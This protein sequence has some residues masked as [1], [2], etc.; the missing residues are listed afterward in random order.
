M[1]GQ[2]AIVI[3]ACIFIFAGTFACGADW[4]QWRGADRDGRWDE[5]GIVSK[6]DSDTLDTVWR[7]EVANGYSGP[8]VADGRVYVT[9]RVEEPIELERVHCFDVKTGDSLWTHKYECDYRRVGYPDGPRASVSID[10]SNAYSVGTMGHLFCLNSKTGKVK[11][12]KEP[13]KDYELK[14]PVWGVSASPM[15]EG[16]LLIV[17]IGAKDGGCIVA[18][19]KISGEEK[20][21]ALDDKASYSSP[22]IVKQAAKRLLICVTGQRVVGLDPQTGKLF[23]EHPFKPKKMVITVPTPVF[24]NNYLFVSSFYDGSLVLKLNPDKL[25]VQK[26]WRRIG[27]NETNTDS[28]HCMISTPVILGEHIY[29]V[30]SYGEL[31]CLDIHTGDRIWEDLTAVPK[32]RWANIHMV[33][34]GKNI[35]MFN[36]RGELVIGRLSPKG[37]QEIS[38]AKLIEP[39]K[40]QLG[41]RNGVCWAHPAY[42]N[43][44]IFI[45]NDNELVCASFAEKK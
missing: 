30:D 42:A 32:A 8:T 21:R 38:R 25:T 41:M 43:K 35:W 39:T 29:G 24:H 33:Q 10:G 14:I 19:D 6:F 36:E 13:G 23:W 17:Q 31:R 3:L 40:G 45:R 28:L 11:W 26:V 4:P 18:Y 7:A 34:N 1:A 5:D 27:K 2:K 16:D 12:S 15:I 44:H 9:D 20:W 37:F 22:I